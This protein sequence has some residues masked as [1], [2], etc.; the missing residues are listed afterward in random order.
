VPSG[1][2]LNE[3]IETYLSVL[4]AQGM[5]RSTI[6][7]RRSALLRF[8]GTVGNIYPRNLRPE[9]VDR[10]LVA[11]AHWSPATRRQNIGY[12]S[13]FQT[14]LQARS[15]LRRDV[16]ICEGRR[17]IRIPKT[18]KVWIKQDQF[19][20]LLDVANNPRDRIILGI[21]IYLA[22]RRSELVNIQWKHVDLGA[23]YVDIYRSKTQED[24]RLPISAE[25][26]TELRRWQ[27]YLCRALGVLHPDR[28][29]YVACAIGPARERNQAGQFVGTGTEAVPIPTRRLPDPL[30]RIKSILASVGIEGPGVGMH[31]LR[32]SGAQ[33]M[34]ESIQRGR[35]DE[36]A[37][38]AVG[39]MLGH[40][41]RQTTEIYLDR[42]VDRARRDSLIRG[43]YLY[44]V[45][46][47]GGNVVRLR[48]NH[49]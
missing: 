16:D 20:K 37:L 49:G 5:A 36:S 43:Q 22:V 39:S 25:L 11:H 26:E 8:L 18:P 24:D 7:C 14:W 23:G 40:K 4:K 35:Y 46:G 48:E 21:G 13:G 45:P 47:T 30:V 9:H 38:D 32:R 42:S 6:V 2:R 29:W 15:L 28:E 34:L 44:G 12:L 1:V 27:A 10:M 31:T 41:S 17:R 19:E 33:A 3:A